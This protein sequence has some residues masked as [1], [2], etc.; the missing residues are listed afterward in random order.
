MPTAMDTDVSPP[1]VVETSRQ[2][3]A[4]EPTKT[5]AG[6][7]P[8]ATPMERDEDEKDDDAPR[9]RQLERP[10]AEAASGDAHAASGAQVRDS[11]LRD[12]RI[13]KTRA[14]VD[15]EK[16]CPF[17]VR[18]YVRTNAEFVPSEI[19]RRGLP[20][21]AEILHTWKDA[22]LREIASLLTPAH[23]LAKERHIAIHF[24]TVIRT[25]TRDSSFRVV[26][27]GTVHNFRPSKDDQKTLDQARF[28]IGDGL[29]VSILKCDPTKFYQANGFGT[30]GSEM[31]L[32]IRIG[33]ATTKRIL[34]SSRIT[35]G[36]VP[37]LEVE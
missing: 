22:S 20:D 16:V 26:P 1:D 31:H 23:P 30:Q 5:T 27:L 33:W 35:E 11:R 15:R 29:L 4:P 10:P 21:K 25:Q 9:H 28:V 6:K 7:S 32:C 19:E 34:D 18:V 24:W 17:L 2:D 12:A 37:R 36:R 3:N 14:A 13:P 8:E